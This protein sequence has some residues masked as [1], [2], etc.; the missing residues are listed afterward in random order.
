MQS[1]KKAQKQFFRTFQNESS[2]NF[3]I[4]M[5]ENKLTK[6]VEVFDKEKEYSTS[7]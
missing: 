5:L 6:F 3:E 4:K 7:A 1:I 2:D